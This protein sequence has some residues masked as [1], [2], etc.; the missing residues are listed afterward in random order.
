VAI[1]NEALA[2]QIF[3][4]AQP[5]GR[6]LHAGT[7][8]TS[9]SLEVVGVVRNA[10]PGDVRISRL[11]IVYRPIVQEPAFLRNPVITVRAADRG[12]LGEAIR[13]AVASFGYNY[14]TS[15]RT[16]DDQIERTLLPERTLS[17]LSL[18][19]GAFS[20]L[21]AVLGLYALLS[22]SLSRR[23]REMALRLAL[24]ATGHMLTLLILREAIL[25][26]TTGILLGAPL[27]W[28]AVKLS[29]SLLSELSE[30]SMGVFCGASV[31]MLIGALLAIA[32]PAFG[33]GRT[34]PATALRLD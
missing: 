6:R 21:L 26:A 29:H 16:V 4:S 32:G 13:Q 23:L 34:E 1:I 25:I 12:G 18:F 15:V 2:E 33:A 30:S 5:I 28:A 11:P 10:S 14:V 22:Y 3:G 17:V 20:I 31:I 9:K 24:G 8:P 7:D 19:V 27:T